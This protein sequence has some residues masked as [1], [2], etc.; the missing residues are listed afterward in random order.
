[1]R[2]RK[3]KHQEEEKQE[4]YTIVC[5]YCGHDKGEEILLQSSGGLS[6]RRP[7]RKLFSFN[8]IVTVRCL[9]C[10]FIISFAKDERS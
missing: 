6:W 7:D 10:N 1:M 8:K 3:R 4:T 9:E 2:K 5:P